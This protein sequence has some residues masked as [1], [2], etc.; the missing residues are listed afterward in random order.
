M[1]FFRKLFSARRAVTR[2]M[3]EQEAQLTALASLP[4]EQLAEQPDDVLCPVL[5]FLNDRAVTAQF[6]APHK[7]R[8]SLADCYAWLPG[9][10][11]TYALADLFSLGM[12][13]DGLCGILT[14]E[15]RCYAW[16]LPGILRAI[17]AVPHAAL[18]EAFFAD[19]EIDPHK[20]SSFCIGQDL[21]TDYAA[22]ELRY[23]YRA[24]N[25]A[26]NQLPP[27]MSCLAAYGRAHLAAFLA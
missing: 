26:Y 27:L 6:G 21:E 11:R 1:G 2:A 25:K 14:G 5:S 18:L 15:E 16:E 3:E 17:G 24:F 23:P 7:R 20:M 22:Q 9:V 12:E 13:T 10:R 8:Q 4:P 19:N